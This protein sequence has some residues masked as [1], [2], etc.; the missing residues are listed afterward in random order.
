M[1]RFLDQRSTAETGH[2]G[3]R[4]FL[5]KQWTYRPVYTNQVKTHQINILLHLVSIRPKTPT[6][7]NWI[8]RWL[9]GGLGLISSPIISRLV[10]VRSTRTSRHETLDLLHQFTQHTSI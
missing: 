10:G 4:T 3:D 5:G 8:L 1:K 9:L 2:F 7:S 6:Y